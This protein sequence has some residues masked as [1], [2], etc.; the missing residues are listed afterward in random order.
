MYSPIVARDVMAVKATVEPNIGSPSTKAAS[1]ISQV[2][3]TGVVLKELTDATHL[4]DQHGQHSRWQVSNEM[5]ILMA[6]AHVL[7]DD[8][9]TC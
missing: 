1:T 9:C 6:I 7:M 2:E 8:S 4:Q 3:T 5:I